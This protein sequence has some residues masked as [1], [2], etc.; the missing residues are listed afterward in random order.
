MP[1]LLVVTIIR[2]ATTEPTGVNIYVRYIY[3]LRF[4]LVWLIT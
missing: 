2:A 1:L 3:G 4:Y